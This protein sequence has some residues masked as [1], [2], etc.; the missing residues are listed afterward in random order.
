MFPYST[1]CTSVRRNGSFCTRKPTDDN[2]WC[3]Q[4]HNLPMNFDVLTTL[5]DSEEEQIQRNLFFSP[6]YFINPIFFSN[7]N[8]FGNTLIDLNTRFVYKIQSEEETPIDYENLLYIGKLQCFE[9]TWFL[10]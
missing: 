8:V 7:T 5:E 2:S 10:E 4:I 6:I 9:G 3:C 1:F